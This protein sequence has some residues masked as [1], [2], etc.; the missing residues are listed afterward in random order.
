MGLYHLAKS[1]ETPVRLQLTHGA[2]IIVLGVLACFAGE[3]SPLMLS[4]ATTAILIVMA[5]QEMLSL[6]TGVPE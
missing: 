6:R 3:M 5:V 1:E 2:G 4:L